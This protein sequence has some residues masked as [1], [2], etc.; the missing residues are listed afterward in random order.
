MLKATAVVRNAVQHIADVVSV[1]AVGSQGGR[2][3]FRSRTENLWK[4]AN[5][6]GVFGG[7]VLGQ[8]LSS[9]G[10]TLREGMSLHSVH[11]HFLLGADPREPIQ[12]EVQ[13][14]RDGGRYASRATLAQQRGKTIFMATSSYHS[15]EPEQPSFQLDISPSWAKPPTS[16]T[17]TSNAT[18]NEIHDV[19]LVS[20]ADID[21]STHEHKTRM[22]A[23]SGSLLP[24]EKSRL[25]EERFVKLLG[26]SRGETGLSIVDPL[27]PNSP[28]AIEAY[29]ADRRS[30]PFEIRD[31]DPNMWDEYG[32]PR[33][34]TR[35]AF[36]LRAR[37]T[38]LGEQQT[39]PADA[40]KLALA[41]ASDFNFL[42]TITKALGLRKA[43]MIVTLD[44]SMWFYRTDFDAH[45]W[46]LYVMQAQ[47]ASNGHGIVF[48]RVYRRDG[49]LIAV[50]VSIPFDRPIF[51]QLTLNLWTGSRRRGTQ[52][53]GKEAGSYR[54]FSPNP[55]NL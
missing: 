9:A 13:R 3:V 18:W 37:E 20:T 34:G 4:P 45:D 35:Q 36:W 43:S 42:P 49:A 32:A 38:I 17:T 53:S 40:N 2:D 51:L 33:P 15:G 7:Q 55:Q 48:G 46:M 26:R 6:R 50:A 39:P 22:A 47:A 1:D 25:T 31:A 23:Y 27:T 41:Y 11:S 28:S 21:T 30:S 14:L 12:Y 19:G 52:R 29:L 54:H 10:R 24:P 8:A 44:H 16:H 5:A